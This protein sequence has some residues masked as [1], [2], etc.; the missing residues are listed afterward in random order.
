MRSAR[1]CHN[2]AHALLHSAPLLPSCP[3][4]RCSTHAPNRHPAA[5]PAA[6]A[7]LLLGLF[8]F[9]NSLSL[10]WLIYIAIIQRGPVAPCSEELTPIPD[11]ATKAAAI[12]ALALPLLVLLP[13]P[14]ALSLGPGGL[15]DLPPTF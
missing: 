9:T 13:F 15:P 12:A 10:F 11:G 3:P 5:T 14:T 1:A 2:A 7:L 8:G 6:A 4:P